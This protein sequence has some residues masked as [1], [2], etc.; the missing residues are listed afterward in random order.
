MTPLEKI[1]QLLPLLHQFRQK[2]AAKLTQDQA[3]I[4]RDVY[5]EIYKPSHVNTGCA[6]CV[7]HYLSMLEAYHHR[8]ST[9]SN[10]IDSQ[11]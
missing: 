1:E 9:K 3:L 4:L 11:V 7:I 5:M 2:G 8:E 6:Q 10:H